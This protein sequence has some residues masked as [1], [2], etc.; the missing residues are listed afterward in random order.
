[1]KKVKIDSIRL[2]GGTQCRVVIDQSTVY[3]YRDLMK[4]DV[5]FP[6]IETVFDGV[7]HWLTDGYHRYHAL[8]LLG[9][10]D[11]E[12]EY[13][14]GTQLDAQIAALRANSRHGKPLTN[15]DKRN[16]IAMAL[17]LPGF[18]EKSSYEIAKLCEVSQSMV[19]AAR[20]PKVKA[21]QAENVKRHFEKK[22][23]SKTSSDEQQEQQDGPSEEELAAN[24][25]MLKADQDAMYKLLDS[26]DALST[27]HEEIK[28]LNHLNAQLEIRMSGLMNEK[29]EAIKMVKQLQKEL[30]KLKP[31]K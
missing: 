19:A 16:K 14:P 11:V 31:K 10:K 26:D 2:D 7:T 13:K 5:S 24:A 18:D 3:A 21:R 29:N 28:R 4:D 27:A 20:D 12:I 8:K 23:T 25:L 30:D 22:N 9:V 15:D 17:A 1:M 6:P